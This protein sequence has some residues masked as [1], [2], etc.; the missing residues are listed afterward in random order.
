MNQILLCPIDQRKSSTIEEQVCLFVKQ[1]IEHFQLIPGKAIPDLELT[2]LSK[3]VQKEVMDRVY[4]QLHEEGYL[5]LNDQNAW[6]VHRPEKLSSEFLTRIMPLYQAIE[7]SGKKA[8]IETLFKEVKI[9]NHHDVL[10]KGFLLNESYLKFVRLFYGNDDVIAYATF[11]VS[12]DLVPTLETV[13]ANNLPHL[14]QLIPMYPG[15]YQFHTREIQTL[16]LPKHIQDVL[17]RQE[18][19]ICVLGEYSFYTRLGRVVEKGSVY[20]LDLHEYSFDIPDGK[21]ILND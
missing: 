5:H 13:I 18:E 1:K 17:G 6:I 8:R 10:H 3:K 4:H 2:N 9:A 20:M 21:V 19:T 15:F 14:Q 7:A 11:C 12:L 16:I